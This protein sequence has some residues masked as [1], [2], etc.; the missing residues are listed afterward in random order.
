V[1]RREK[2]MGK[3]GEQRNKSKSKRIRSK[4]ERGGQSASFI[5]GWASLAVAR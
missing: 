4:R 2:G 3:G 1:E 5:G